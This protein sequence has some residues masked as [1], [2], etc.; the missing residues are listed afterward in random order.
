VF[1]AVGIQHAKRMRH[2]VVF[3]MSGCILFLHIISQTARF[4]TSVEHDISVVISSAILSETSFIVRGIQ[5]DVIVNVH[6]SACQVPA[7]LLR[8]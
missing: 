6:R 1:V 3:D 7:F 2:F 5:R 8:Y 4:C